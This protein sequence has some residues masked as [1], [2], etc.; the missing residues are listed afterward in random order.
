[1]E[2]DIQTDA[3]TGLKAITC[4]A[5]NNNRYSHTYDCYLTGQ[6]FLTYTHVHKDSIMISLYE[7]PNQLSW[8]QKPMSRVMMITIKTMNWS[9]KMWKEWSWWVSGKNKQEVAALL[10]SVIRWLL[11]HLNELTVS[12]N[13]S[14]FLLLHVVDNFMKLVQ[15]CSQL[16]ILKSTNVSTSYRSYRSAQLLL[17]D[18]IKHISKHKRSNFQAT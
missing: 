9:V 14:F 15:L 5:A 3:Q 12:V 17:I 6:I 4:F 10:S 1:L 8:K 13:Y 11:D 7:K 2:T 16:L 18:Q